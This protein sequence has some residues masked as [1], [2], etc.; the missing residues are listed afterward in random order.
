MQTL[1]E[2]NQLLKSD[3]AQAALDGCLELIK[4]EPDN[5]EVHYLASQAQLKL[6]N[7]EAAEKHIKTAVKKNLEAD[8][9]WQSLGQVQLALQKWDQAKKAFNKSI[10]INPNL[11]FSYLAVGDIHMIQNQMEKAKDNYT[12]ALRVY[13]DGVPAIVKL[14]RIKILEG[15]IEHAYEDLMAIH[16]QHPEEINV[17]LHLG[18][19]KFE[20]GETGLA[21]FYFRSVLERDE[22]DV[23]AQMY[24]AMS[25][26]ET[27]PKTALNLI[28]SVFE[29][30]A[31]Q[32]ELH[33]AMGMYH[34]HNAEYQDAIKHLEKITITHL[35]YPSWWIA[36]AEALH[37]SGKKAQATE[38]MQD[39]QKRTGRVDGLLK[40]AELTQSEGQYPAALAAYGNII[41]LSEE[42]DQIRMQMG[43]CQFHGG[44]YEAALKRFDTVLQQQSDLPLALIY[45][46]QCLIA[47]Q[48]SDDVLQLVESLDSN[49]FTP[50]Q[51]NRV[52][53]MTGLM[54]DQ[55]DRHDE[56]FAYFEKQNFAESE[57]LRPFD[58]ETEALVTSWSYQA[59]DTETYRPIFL[60]AEN[61]TGAAPFVDWLESN[62]V[63]LSDH[64]SSARDRNDFLSQ[65][66]SLEELN[67]LTDTDI[68]LLRKKYRQ[69]M[70]RKFPP[71]QPVIDVIPCDP[72]AAI[73]IKRIYPDASLL[74]LSRNS[75]DIHLD[76]LIHGPGRI[77]S[78]QMKPILNQIISLG[79]DI[80]II[81][82]DAWV[83]N[84]EEAVST[85]SEL[86]S[87]KL[88]P[89]E[90]TA[91]SPFQRQLLPMGHW[92]NYKKL[93]FS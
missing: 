54:L 18:I 14:A 73:I 55:L 57:S 74:L 4:Q 22:N 70:K 12:L 56:A 10:E 16:Q 33:A 11:F 17:R 61:M 87:D 92:R 83:G 9:Y 5:A 85:L 63:L 88:K 2:L 7:I 52:Y 72:I 67:L 71:E 64:R 69:K 1:E 81:D 39:L 59:Q 40:L 26:A 32:L 25:L 68:H 44:D 62:D 86:L 53:R 49:N 75:L 13:D 37:H 84:N 46:I 76:Q 3:E 58:K 27:E 29:K 30:T 24:L 50:D 60:M 91:Q 47:L 82:I 79:L 93:K 77:H 36:Y 21:E 19:A 8:K 23:S 31:P 35:S 38:L 6:N 48:K 66:W 80:S 43:I 51:M 45:K 89:A 42:T 90:M 78:D 20:L 28:R 34:L 65:A 41:I 15:K